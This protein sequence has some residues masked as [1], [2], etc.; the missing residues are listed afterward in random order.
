M[1]ATAAPAL[2]VHA[3][4]YR[5]SV[6]DGPGL[7]TVL[8]LQGCDRRCPGCHN[9]QTWEHGAGR[10]VPV[11]GLAAEIRA[12]SRTPAL[13]LSGGEPLLQTA[14]VLELISL[15]PEFSIALYTGFELHEVPEV[16]LARL[17]Y[18]KVGAFK[19]EQRRSDLPFVGSTNQ[20]FVSLKG[21]RR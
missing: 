7:R 14:G 11:G 16:L 2:V 21:A 4:D 18:V 15:L 17:D 12:C 13:T 10:V 6:V 1:L 19:S 8:F 3:V 20:S 5:G 9:P